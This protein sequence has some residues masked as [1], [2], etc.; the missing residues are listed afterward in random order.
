MVNTTNLTDRQIEVLKMRAGGITQSQVAQQL[1][2]TKANI[3]I[4]E[5]QARNNITRAKNT[6]ELIKI[7]NAPIW[8]KVVPGTDIYEIPG[9]IFNEADIHNIWIPKG[10]P[11]LLSLIEEKAQNKLRERRVLHAIEI[12]ITNE[13]DIL[14]Q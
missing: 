5:A 10:G 3:S 8:I 1:G 14:V 13:G 7:I 9:M 2:T 4:I 11:S 6:V 12:G